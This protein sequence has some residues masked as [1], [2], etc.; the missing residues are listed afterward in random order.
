MTRRIVLT[1]P[2]CTGKTTLAAEVATA[3]HAPWLPEASRAY[4]AE[5]LREGHA[6]TAGDVE[7][8]AIRAVATEDAA[9]A[10]APP[11]L[12]LDTDLLSTVVYSRHYY[13]ACPEW[14][15]EEARVRRAECYLLCLPDIPWEADGVRD[16]PQLRDELLTL[17]RDTLEELE[18]RVVE[19]SG[20]GPARVATAVRAARAALAA[21]SN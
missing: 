15:E 9:L 11:V 3:L 21:T 13:G 20:A 18:C 12:V 19:V 10:L 8:I 2:E 16:L 17:F 5:R 1:G 6:L 4:A 7:P 14:I